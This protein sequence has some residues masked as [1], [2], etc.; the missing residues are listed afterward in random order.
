MKELADGTQVIARM[1][2][3]LDYNDL[4]NKDYIKNVLKNMHLRN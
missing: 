4:S 1:Y 3:L 2:Y